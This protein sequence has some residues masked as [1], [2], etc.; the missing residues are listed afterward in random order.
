[1]AK[2]LWWKNTYFWLAAILFAVGVWGLPFVGGHEGI[3][4]PGQR[5]EG[6][7]VLIYWGGALVMLVNG[8]ISHRHT[9]L[10]Y[11]ERQEEGG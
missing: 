6:G 10:M 9:V 7:L 11:Q 5:D 3:R 8:L 2:P 1:M 4:D